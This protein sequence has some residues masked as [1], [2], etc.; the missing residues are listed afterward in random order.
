LSILRS[1][2]QPLLFLCFISAAGVAAVLAQ[3]A[4][5]APIPFEPVVGQ[6]GKDVVWVPTPQPLVEKMLD[7]AQVTPQDYVMDLGSGDGR[8]IIA[9]A[10]RGARALGVEYNPDMVELSR[11]AAEQ[12][13]VADK[14]Q[15][16]QGDMYAAD[17]SEATVMA[18]FLL[19]DNLEKLTPK[20]VDLKPGS[21][22]VLNGFAIPGWDPD[23][24]ERAEG[25]CGSWCT[26]M[27][28]IVPARV[29]GAWRLGKGELTINQRFQKFSGTL[30]RDGTIAQ[31]KDGL[32]HGDEITFTAGGRKYS[33]RVNGDAIQGAGGAWRATRGKKVSGP[34]SPTS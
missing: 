1:V 23:V 25:D 16:V 24:T 19:P 20:F 12:E 31:I 4:Q 8:N 27:L 17:I 22:M 21:R 11:R 14:A 32:L 34:F 3:D 33:G 26:A 30:S 10:K 6:G 5:E 2:F 15:F 7:L 13:G 18:L 9:A 28:Y 29:D